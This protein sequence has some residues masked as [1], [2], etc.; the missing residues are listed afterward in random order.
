MEHRRFGP[1]GANHPSLGKPCPACEVPFAVGD[2]TTLVPIGPG[3]DPEGRERARAG[4]VY[5]AVAIEA[6]W[7]CVTGKEA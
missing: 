7:V 5:T 6:H 1:K 2:F 4:R 3:S